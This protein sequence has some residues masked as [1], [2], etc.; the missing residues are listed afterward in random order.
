MENNLFTGFENENRYRLYPFSESSSLED[1]SG[2]VLANDVIIDAMLYPVNPNGTIRMTAFDCKEGLI[3]FSD[4]SG[5]IAS[6]RVYKGSKFVTLY[7]SPN[8]TNYTCDTD[9]V[10]GNPVGKVVFG[11]GFDRELATGRVHYYGNAVLAPSA[12]CPVAFSGVKSV[13][14]VGNIVTRLPCLDGMSPSEVHLE[15]RVIGILGEG[16][17]VSRMGVVGDRKYMWFDV[18]QSYSDRSGTEVYER[19]KKPSSK[20]PYTAVRTLV[21]AVEGPSL[22]DIEYM[23]DDD[24]LVTMETLDR[25]DICYQANLDAIAAKAKIDVCPDTDYDKDGMSCNPEPG[26]PGDPSDKSKSYVILNA[27]DAGLLTPDFANYKNPVWIGESSERTSHQD[28]P[29][30]TAGMTSDEATAEIQKLHGNPVSGG[31][32]LEIAIPGAGRVG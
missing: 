10:P 23:G 1:D 14:V 18:L 32:S 16:R 11:P 4:D 6:G 21:V 8:G 13:S 26:S 15:D 19:K 3:V 12:M 20:K 30:I 17:L 29:R 22:F 27:Y 25:E 9:D 31:G 5:E 24:V 28:Y 7:D 2:S